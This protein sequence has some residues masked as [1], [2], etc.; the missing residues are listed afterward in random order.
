MDD[1][2]WIREDVLLAIHNRQLAEHGGEPGVR[3]MGL[4]QSALG[5]PKNL[6][7]YSDPKP[8]WAVLAASYAFGIARNHAFIDGNKRTALV[9]CRT[10]LRLNGFEVVAPDGD[11]YSTFL[12]LAAGELP[13]SELA[14]WLRG[15]L[16]QRSH[17]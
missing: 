5:R 8:D 6:W 9:V 11:K 15:H 3:D 4:L 14:Q 17:A 2:V 12:G 16:Q 1:P 10:F 13:E 7:A